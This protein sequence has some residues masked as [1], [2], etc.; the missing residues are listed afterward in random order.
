MTRLRIALVLLVAGLVAV[1]VLAF[2]MSPVSARSTFIRRS[3]GTVVTGS[4]GNTV[5]VDAFN[6]TGQKTKVT[7]E[8]KIGG[9]FTGALVQESTIDPGQV[10]AFNFNCPNNMYCGGVL[11]VK[12]IRNVVL[13]AHWQL[14]GTKYDARAGDF[15][16]Y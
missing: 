2:D 6:P 3:M 9:N 10:W 5:V 13:D 8:M 7:V 16:R 4:S 14:D 12:S 11:T 1:V 15:A